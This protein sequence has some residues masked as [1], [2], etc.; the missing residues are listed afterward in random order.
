MAS[1]EGNGYGSDG[2]IRGK[3]PWSAVPGFDQVEWKAVTTFGAE[4][5]AATAWSVLTSSTLPATFVDAVMAETATR[6]L[7]RQ[8]RAASMGLAI[9]GRSGVAVVQAADWKIRFTNL[10]SGRFTE[11]LFERAYRE[12]LEDLGLEL[13]EEAALRNWI[14]FRI[15]DPGSQFQVAI[16]VKNAGVQYRE[17]ERWVGLLP[18][19]TLPIATYKIFGS[20]V[21]PIP[22]LIYVYLVDWTLLSRLRAAYWNEVLSEEERLVFQM[23][24]GIRGIP[25]AVEDAFIEATVGDRLDALLNLTGLAPDD[26]PFRAISGARCRR[27]F[28]ENHGRSPYVY[29]QRMNTDPNVHVSVN[30][31]TIPFRQLI[32]RFLTTPHVRSTL[33]SG[34]AA[35]EQMDVPAPP[36]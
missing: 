16:N 23:L 8:W 32:D 35:V 14:D 5:S 11:R 19:D 29:R 24:T 1:L 27:V 25:R 30:T 31:E 17:S 18:A 22:P 36:I 15:S 9:P 2:D 28:F 26:P 21:A 7:L 20:E 34:L 3:L 33:L 13:T 6:I 12:D 10:V 4:P